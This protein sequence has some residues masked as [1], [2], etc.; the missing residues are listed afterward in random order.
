MTDTHNTTD[1]VHTEGQTADHILQPCPALQGKH[2]SCYSSPNK[3][4]LH[5]VGD[6]E[7]GN[8]HHHMWIGQLAKQTCIKK[9][10]QQQEKTRKNYR[11][12]DKPTRQRQESCSLVGCSTSQQH[13]SVSRRWRE[14][15]IQNGRL[16]QRDRQTDRQTDRDRKKQRQTETQRQRQTQRKRESE[17]EKDCGKKMPPQ[18]AR[19]NTPWPIPNMQT[20]KKHKWTSELPST[21]RRS[22]IISTWSC[23]RQPEYPG[24]AY[25]PVMCHRKQH[26]LQYIY[27]R[28]HN[29]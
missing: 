21:C 11:Q 5:T 16:I 20:V 18:Q 19:F 22:L 29:R 13:D 8:I 26:G 23:E 14:T 12:T 25:P 17:R 24:E 2:Q 27:K 15:Y 6:G 4:L 9:K 3:T 28:I 1:H 10:Q 7:D